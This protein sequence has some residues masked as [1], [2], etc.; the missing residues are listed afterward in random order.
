MITK[1][2]IYKDVWYLIKKVMNN[3][4]WLFYKTISRILGS[5]KKASLFLLENGID[6][7]KKSESKNWHDYILFNDNDITIEEIKYDPY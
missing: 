6:G 7:L 3:L 5:D 1:F 4:G 2:E